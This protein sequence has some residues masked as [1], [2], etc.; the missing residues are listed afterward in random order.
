MLIISAGMQK[1]GSAYFYNVIND[2]LVASGKGKDAREIKERWDLDEELKWHNNNIGELTFGKLFKLWKISL[3]DGSFVVKTHAGP[4]RAAEIL[5]RLGMV[6]VVYSY[7]D[8]RDV[9]LSAIDHG[10]RILE[11]GEQHTFAKMATFDDAIDSKQFRNWLRIWKDYA[12]SPGVLSLQYEE[13]LE[14][15]S[16]VAR[17]IEKFLRLPVDEK[18]REDILWK[19]SKDNTEGDRTGMH[20]NKASSA[21]HISEMTEEQQ[22][23]CRDAFGSVLVEMGYESA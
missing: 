7:R 10:K 14:N 4:S 8:P 15:P 11:E 1:S 19:Y 9:L 17:R 12:S 20:F 5:G 18:S 16:D 21:R 22:Q 13:M 3:R 2:L 23:R 6:R